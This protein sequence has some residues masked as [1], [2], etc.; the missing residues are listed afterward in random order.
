MNS[1]T[2]SFLAI[3]VFLIL[4]SVF[5]ALRYHGIKAARTAREDSLWRLSYDVFFETT[6]PN[7]EVRIAWPME[8]RYCRV[9]NEV[10][11]AGVLKSQGHGPYKSTG[12]QEWWVSA[13]Q[14][15]KYNFRASFDLRLS[16]RAN[17]SRVPPLESL[18]PDYR[19]RYLDEDGGVIPTNTKEVLDLAQTIPDEGTD[20]QRVQWIF[21]H[22][23][24]IDGSGQ[25]DTVKEALET[26]KGSPL[27]KARAM[28]ALCRSIRIPARLVVGF[29]IKQGVNLKPHVWAEVF[30]RQ[31]WIPFDPDRKS[32]KGRH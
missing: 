3:G 11:T 29:E 26:G 15:D 5:I 20:A 7:D 16:P 27:A 32:A 23:A 19:L 14:P 9:V 30:Q 25:L 8:T 18:S 6:S 4:G 12:F 22:C 17:M 1:R 2:L 10:E 24:G 21:D 31:S 13:R 28:V